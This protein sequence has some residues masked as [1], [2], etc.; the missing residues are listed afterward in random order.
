MEPQID[1][2]ALLA[3]L[4]APSPDSPEFIP[5]LSQT[6]NL[7]PRLVASMMRDDPDGVAQLLDQVGAPVPEPSPPSL[8]KSLEESEG[9]TAPSGRFTDSPGWGLDILGGRPEPAPPP[10][11]SPPLPT[12][13]RGIGSDYAAN[14]VAGLLPQGGDPISGDSRFNQPATPAE[15]APGGPTAASKIGALLTAMERVQA[16]EA[17]VGQTIDT[18]AAPRVEPVAGG[19][20]GALIAAMPG[21]KLDDNRIRLMQALGRRG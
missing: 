4:Q 20:L 9:A 10:A 19:G 6:L 7:D 1:L 5:W 14:P 18:P 8:G 3:E 2:G 17:P 11:A 13:Q 15:A 12:G 16:P 21:M